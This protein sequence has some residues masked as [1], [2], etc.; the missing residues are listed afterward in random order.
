M[1]QSAREV[2]TLFRN[3]R[4]TCASA[5]AVGKDFGAV[6]AA[7]FRQLVLFD[8]LRHAFG[9]EDMH[10][11]LAADRADVLEVLPVKVMHVVP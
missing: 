7:P 2:E 11:G 10:L 3:H 5:P 1:G 9:T 6:R 8:F 4:S